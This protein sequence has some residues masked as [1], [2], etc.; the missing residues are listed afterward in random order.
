MVCRSRTGYRILECEVPSYPNSLSSNDGL[1]VM[2]QHK[3]YH[4][5]DILFKPVAGYVE[6]VIGTRVEECLKQFNRL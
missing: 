5:V 1:H 6:E 4:S 3:Y 2:V